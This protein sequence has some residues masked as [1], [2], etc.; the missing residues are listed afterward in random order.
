MIKEQKW[1][2]K[3]IGYQIYPAS[4]FDANNDGYGD[5]AGII[6]KL[7]YLKDLGVNLIWVCPFFKSP[8]DDNGYDI[9][10]H[11]EVDPMFGETKDMK[12]LIDEIHVRGMKVIFDF[13]LNHTSDEHPWFIESRQNKNNPKRD[14]YIW[15]DGK[16][17]NGKRL[18]PN[19][20]QGFFSDSAWAYDEQSDSF[21]MKIF[22][23]K[24]PDLNWANPKMRQEIYNIARFYLN[25]GCDGFRLDAVAHL[26]RDL[27]FK[28][29]TYP[30]NEMGMV[31]DF[32][33]FSNRPQI[34]DYLA[35]F[36]KEVLDHYDCVTVGEVGGAVSV[37]DSLKY[38][39]Y[40][41]GSL[42]MVFNFDT[43]WENGAYDSL[44]LA[45]DEL[46]TRVKNIKWIFNNWF[47]V[48]YG[49]AWLPLYWNNHDHPRVLSQY[50]SIK[51]RKESAKMLGL[52]LLFMYGTP[53]IYNGEE[54]GMSNTTYKSLDDFKDVSDQNY[55]NEVKDRIPHDVLLRFMNRT[56]RT[57]GHQIMQ[58]SDSK[59][60]GFSKHEPWL[61]VNENY[62]EVNVA[63]QLNDEDS[64]LNF[65]KKAIHLRKK[66]NMINLVINTRFCLIDAENDDVFAYTHKTNEEEIIVI[67][68]FRNYEVIFR[69]HVL[70]V[71]QDV[72]LHNYKDI[73]KISDDSLKLRPFE[74]ML[75][76]RRLDG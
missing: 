11:F 66:D 33:K 53:F 49:K 4:F 29:S 74:A 55:I 5:L 57:N 70:K 60:A 38:S 52:V 28:D 51:Y 17:E 36:K 21:Y 50:G 16:R 75:L 43:C 61:K 19:N 7:D 62:K 76:Y 34:Y 8:K 47:N 25:L 30:T 42:N 41:T 27:T 67:A 6:Q 9:S 24:M 14:F 10:N 23:K 44:N 73:A 13:V 64:I 45:D 26:A 68:S 2:Q 65:Y 18:P 32:R 40:E 20:W 48:C 58:W 56:A 35:E 59:N 54:I 69:N 72:L 1:W 46:R 15:H 3:A 63:E 37:E 31:L 71:K 22:S 12:R 39:G